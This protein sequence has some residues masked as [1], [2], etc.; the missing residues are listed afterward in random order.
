MATEEAPF[1]FPTPITPYHSKAYP[2]IDPTRPELS[3]KGKN[4][5]ITGAGAGIGYE[6]ALRFAKSG[7]ANIGIIGRRAA[8]LESAKTTIESASPDT[9]VHVL[10]TDIVDSA[11]LQAAADTFIAALPESNKKIDVLV[12]NASYLMKIKA[13]EESDPT[14]WWDTFEINV[15]GSFNLLRAFG[16]AVAT[17]GGVVINVSSGAA[18]LP[19]IPGYAAYHSSKLA[20]IKVF[21]YYGI[22]HPGVRVVHMHPGVIM[23]EMG[24]AASTGGG[25]KMPVDDI[26]LPASFAV[27]AASPEAAFLD[28][29]FVWAHWDVDSMKAQ[30]AEII[31]NP[32]KFTMTLS[33]FPGA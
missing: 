1:Q 16:P 28:R 33:G 23:T 2:A 4:I 24:V 5:V 15:R 19:Y 20:A 8:L 13:I 21:D 27:W 29:R 25:P 30:A 11:A 6:M 7:A 10:V 17:D 22:E 3:T 12:A 31:A 26:D 18:H 14:D 32:S 9:K